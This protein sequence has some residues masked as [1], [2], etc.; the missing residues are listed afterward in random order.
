MRASLLSVPFD[1]DAYN[2]GMGQAPATNLNFFGVIL[3]G[4]KN[5]PKD[6]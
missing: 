3:S 6:R 4:A 2:Q 1:Q 5:R